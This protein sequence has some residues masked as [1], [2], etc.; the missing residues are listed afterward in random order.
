MKFQYIRFFITLFG[1]HIFYAGKSRVKVL[2]QS[3]PTPSLSYFV[4]Q[5]Q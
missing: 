2:R 1:T 5:S 3:F 4:Q